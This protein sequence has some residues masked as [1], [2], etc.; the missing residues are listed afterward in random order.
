MDKALCWIYENL[1]SNQLSQKLKY[2]LSDMEHL[3]NC[4]EITAFL[5]NEKFTESLFV[6]LTSLELNQV[7][8]LSQIEQTLYCNKLNT[9]NHRRSTSHP[10]FSFVNN[11]N[12]GKSTI[13][14]IPVIETT[15]TSTDRNFHLNEVNKSQCVNDKKS[16]KLKVN[17]TIM[18][19]SSIKKKHIVNLKLRPWNSLPDLTPDSILSVSS[20]FASLSSSSSSTVKRFRC[21]TIS[22]DSPTSSSSLVQQQFLPLTVEN[23][24]KINNNSSTAKT[25][26]TEIKCITISND[27]NN[28]Q[29]VPSFSYK[30]QFIQNSGDSININNYDL[31]LQ[32]TSLLKCDD[33]KI[34]FDRRHIPNTIRNDVNEATNV[35]ASALPEQQSLLSLDLNVE[36]S[37]TSSDNN[38]SNTH[39]NNNNNVKQTAFLNNLLSPFTK[40]NDKSSADMKYN[41]MFSTSAPADFVNTFLTIDGEKLQNRYRNSTVLETLNISPTNYNYNNIGQ[42]GSPSQELSPL[43]MQMLPSHGQSLTSYLQ[44]AQF[45]HGNTDLERE[46]AH[47]NVSEAMISAIEQIKWSE[48]E[49]LKKKQIRA[50]E[51]LY[52]N[53]SEMGTVGGV[54]RKLNIKQKRWK[55]QHQHKQQLQQREAIDYDNYENSKYS[56]F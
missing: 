13:K 39:N 33:I 5:R 11:V 19:K 16:H 23:L 30:Q 14:S 41:T 37:S 42:S 18:N 45:S 20:T 32:P 28:I 26:N 51:K 55:Q 44:A 17:S 6:C 3:S 4:Y 48:I 7:N 53:S 50:V 56:R 40:N 1:E 35:N 25:C 46:N 43:T 34:H 52:E 24:E 29:K 47:F 22:E 38:D 36:N 54:K 21:N 10:N 8:L 27:N 31:L 49:K 15:T 2:L 12:I 9:I